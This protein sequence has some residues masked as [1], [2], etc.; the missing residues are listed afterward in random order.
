VFCKSGLGLVLGIGLVLG[1]QL[2]LGFSL[3]LHLGLRCFL[4]HR[5]RHLG[6]KFRFRHTTGGASIMQFS[7][8]P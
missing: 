6:K 2:G 8:D 1:L 4:T 3:V 7:Q 5:P